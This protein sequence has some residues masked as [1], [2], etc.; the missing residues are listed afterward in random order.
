MHVEMSFVRN[1]GGLMPPAAAKRSRASRGSS[2]ERGPAGRY[3]ESDDC[4]VPRKPRTKPSNIGGGYDTYT[5]L[6]AG[7]IGKHIP[8]NPDVIV[9]NMPG[10]GSMKVANHTYNVAPKDGTF[11]G[12]FSMPVAIEPLLGRK[13]AK[14][15]A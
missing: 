10:G 6:L 14:F 3:E 2:I 9:T 13:N 1:L 15:E 7:F 11:L 4:I 12:V 5:R 8:G